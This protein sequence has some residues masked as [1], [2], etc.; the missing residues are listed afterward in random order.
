MLDIGACGLVANHGFQFSDLDSE[1]SQP[2]PERVLAIPEAIKRGY[3]IE[4]IHE[5]SHIDEWFLNR[6]Q[7]IVR[8]EKKLAEAGRA[9]DPELVREAKQFGFADRQIAVLTGLDETEVRM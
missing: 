6:I 3:S 4:R 1:L 5:L 9:L 8:I 2:T 7:N